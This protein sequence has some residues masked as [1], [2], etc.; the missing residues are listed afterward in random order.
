MCIVGLCRMT[1]RQSDRT[2]LMVTPDASA[3][4]AGSLAASPVSCPTCSRRVRPLA[5]IELNAA[6]SHVGLHGDEAGRA[7]D[8]DADALVLLGQDGCIRT[9]GGLAFAE[10]HVRAG[11]VGDL[12]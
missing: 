5:H 6:V 7:G 9:L 1:A 2:G 4:A 3:G 12:E 11:L 10:D 8:E